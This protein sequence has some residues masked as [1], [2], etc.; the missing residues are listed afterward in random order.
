MTT[1]ASYILR[2]ECNVILTTGMHYEYLG[3]QMRKSNLVS[4]ELTDIENINKKLASTCQPFFL[5]LVL[6]REYA[7]SFK[8][9]KHQH[10][11]KVL[12]QY[13]EIRLLI[14]LS[15]GIL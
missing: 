12:G 4:V 1:S 7:V 2:H 3:F 13:L 5:W 11:S 8:I 15:V 10:V 6:N 9:Y 14:I